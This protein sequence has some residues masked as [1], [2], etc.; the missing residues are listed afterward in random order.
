MPVFTC[1]AEQGGVHDTPD[2]IGLA[3]NRKVIEL[4]LRM[5]HQNQPQVFIEGRAKLAWLRFTDFLSHGAGWCL[6]R[7][8]TPAK[9]KEFEFVEPETD[10]TVYLFTD[11]RYSVLCVGSRRFYFDRV[12]GQFDGTSAPASVVSDRVELRD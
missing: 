11:A 9:L 2:G 6:E 10:Q 7:I 12:S 8:G 4:D 5:R 1:K 3:P